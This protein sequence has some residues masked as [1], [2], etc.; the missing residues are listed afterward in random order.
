MNFL[1]S[2]RF[3]GLLPLALTCILLTA[4]RL[5]SSAAAD[6]CCAGR[7]ARGEQDTAGL[8]IHGC[9]SASADGTSGVS[10]IVLALDAAAGFQGSIDANR[11]VA[12]DL[13][14]KL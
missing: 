10:V 1:T 13:Q 14:P 4:C 5:R 9:N 11:S 12:G 6:G 8:K 7:S 3:A 2:I